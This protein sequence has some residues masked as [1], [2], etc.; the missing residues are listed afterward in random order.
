MKFDFSEYTYFCIT[1]NGTNDQLA[2]K[3]LWLS[4]AL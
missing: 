3:D 1:E 4:V 2:R